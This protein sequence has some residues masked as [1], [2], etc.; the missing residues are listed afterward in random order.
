MSTIACYV[1]T[2]AKVLAQL[3]THIWAWHNLQILDLGGMSAFQMLG[4]MRSEESQAEWQHNMDF[5]PEVLHKVNASSFCCAELYLELTYADHKF[6]LFPVLV[7]SKY[8]AGLSIPKSEFSDAGTTST[9]KCN[10]VH[11]ML[12]MFD[13]LSYWPANARH[14]TFCRSICPHIAIAGLDIAAATCTSTMIYTLHWYATF[15]HIYE[16]RPAAYMVSIQHNLIWCSQTY[17]PTT[18]MPKQREGPW[19]LSWL[20]SY[21]GGQRGL[22]LLFCPWKAITNLSCLCRSTSSMP[23]LEWAQSGSLHPSLFQPQHERRL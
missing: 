5:Q 8:A 20:E 11:V 22:S 18:Y 15:H 17:L 16:D 3:K 4:H 14:A 13:K 1:V 19:P 9:E 12:A 2:R 21:M 6:S 7:V 10:V 23:P